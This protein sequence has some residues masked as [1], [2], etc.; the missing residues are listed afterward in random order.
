MIQLLLSNF[1]AL[2]SVQDFCIGTEMWHEVVSGRIVLVLRVPNVIKLLLSQRST[3]L[4]GSDL[5]VFAELWNEIVSFGC[6]VAHVRVEFVSDN[7]FGGLDTLGDGLDVGIGSEVGDEVVFRMASV[8]CGGLPGEEWLPVNLHTVSAS[9]ES[10]DCIRNLI[11][12]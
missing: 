1:G 5:L 11:L 8:G 10:N 2:E 4:G 6:F 9:K 7:D 3:G 12:H